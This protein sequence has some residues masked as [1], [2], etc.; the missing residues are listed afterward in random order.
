ME[1]AAAT[2]CKEQGNIRHRSGDFFQ[3]FE[4]YTKAIELDRSNAV[5]YRLERPEQA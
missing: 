3:A 5:L 1:C 4:L 2:A